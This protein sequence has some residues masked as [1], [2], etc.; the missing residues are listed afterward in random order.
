MIIGLISDTHISPKKGKLNEKIF[1]IF[2]NVDLILHAGDITSQKVLDELSE[3]A[4]VTAVLGNNDEL[5]LNKSE[6]INANGKTIVL[7]HGDK[8]KDLYEFG[9]KNNADIVVSGHT[10]SPNF[11]KIKK[12]YLI[13]S[14][15]ASKSVAVLKIEKEIEV[16]FIE[17]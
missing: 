17:I 15:R 14:G 8:I 10:H 13:N 4:P 12:I 7:V 3:I 11:E 9:L 5:D 6:T 1:E 2:E 16:K